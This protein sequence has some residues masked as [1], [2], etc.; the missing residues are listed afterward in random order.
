MRFA[1]IF[2]VRGESAHNEVHATESRS[3]NPDS[4][5]R[6]SG[7]ISIAYR[8]SMHHMVYASDAIGRLVG[9]VA[10][11]R[12][13]CALVSDDDAGL[14]WAVRSR[15]VAGLTTGRVC[16]RSQPGVYRAW[17]GEAG[18]SAET[19]QPDIGQA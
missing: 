13:R 3:L 14:G 4:Q 10:D 2:R 19:W 8:S 1:E 11:P 5:D 12:H 15:H 17:P 9:G 7:S 16:L 18:A 6:T